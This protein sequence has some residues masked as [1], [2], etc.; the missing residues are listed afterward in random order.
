MELIEVME[1]D[2][3][4]RPFPCEW[5]DCGKSFNRKSDLQ[6]HYRIHTNER[7]YAC[8][9]AGCD[10]KFIQRSALTVHIRTHTGEKPHVCQHADCDKRFSDSS[11]LARHRRIHTGKRPYTCQHYNCAKTF[12]RKTTMIKHQRRSHQPGGGPID[13]GLYDSDDDESSPTTP[14]PS[15]FHYPQ[16]TMQQNPMGL[17]PMG[18]EY[19]VTNIHGVRHS[20]LPSN[21]PA[22]FHPP[23][24]QHSQMMRRVSSHGQLY[25]SDG[26]GI[27]TMQPQYHN[28]VPRSNCYEPMQHSPGSFSSGSVRSPIDDGYTFA[29]PPPTGAAHQHGISS[30]PPATGQQ[31][32]SSQLLSVPMQ[33]QN[34]HHG[35]QSLHVTHDIYPHQH[36]TSGPNVSAYEHS[37]IPAYQTSLPMHAMPMQQ[38]QLP[39]LTAFKM[40]SVLQLPGQ[41]VAEL[42]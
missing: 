15:S 2:S 6:R 23:S 1:A 7:P 41:R 14:R 20:S 16:A 8:N 26:P 25:V 11:S 5:E 24:M 3:Q 37:S 17:H 33:S 31:I 18:P 28:Q 27:S 9:W 21:G 40:E 32:L 22:D 12:C 19:F 29:P 36:A 30:Y 42:H 38:Y 39:D 4:P 10:K 34:S 35:H 13:D